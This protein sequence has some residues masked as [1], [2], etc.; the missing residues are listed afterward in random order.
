M[1]ARTALNG[2]VQL[3][4]ELSGKRKHAA[5]REVPLQ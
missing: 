3:P 1:H 5:V 4:S 2:A